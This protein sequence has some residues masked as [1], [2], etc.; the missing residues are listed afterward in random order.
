MRVSLWNLN[1]VKSAQPKEDSWE[2]R[3]E[4]IANLHGRAYFDGC[5]NLK[6]WI[7][8]E[9]T[10]EIIYH[11]IISIMKIQW[12]YYYLLLTHSVL[13][14]RHSRVQILYSNIRHYR[15]RMDQIILIVHRFRVFPNRKTC[16]QPYIVEVHLGKV[17]GKKHDTLIS[18]YLIDQIESQCLILE[19]GE[20]FLCL[21]NLLKNSKIIYTSWRMEYW[22]VPRS[23][24]ESMI[25]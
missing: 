5:F 16:M 8:L 23:Y 18:T 24:Y 25:A 6:L 9:Q 15:L 12:A 22:W 7:F 20:S 3:R 14:C 2:E 4:T 17:H 11:K 21:H 19:V 13:K 10:C 1:E